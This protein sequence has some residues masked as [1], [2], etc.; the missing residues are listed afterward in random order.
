[1]NSHRFDFNTYHGQSYVINV[2]LHFNSDS[3]S[4]NDFGFLPVDVVKNE[5]DRLCKETYW[6]HK[7]DTLH[8]NG[9]NS[10]FVY[11]KVD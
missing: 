11:Y 9:M 5:T 2:A 8:P 1:M 10:K 6:I 4:L 7:L 3:H